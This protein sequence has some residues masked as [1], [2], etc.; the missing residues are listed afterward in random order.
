MS[1]L[2]KSSKIPFVIVVVYL[3]LVLLATISIFT[4][5]DPLDAILLVVLTLPWSFLITPLV[6]A[7]SPS[8][9]D[10][11]VVGVSVGLVGAGINAVLLYLLLGWIVNRFRST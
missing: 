11:V 7:I 3:V 9:F 8:L 2:K 5:D 4:G 10:N 6:D 1:Q